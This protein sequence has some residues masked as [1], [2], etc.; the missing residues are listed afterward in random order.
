MGLLLIYLVISV[1]QLFTAHRKMI[2][3]SIAIVFLLIVL[4]ILNT[5]CLQKILNA[6]AH[7]SFHLSNWIQIIVYLAID[8]GSFFAVRYILKN[9]V[10][11]IV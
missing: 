6:A 3:F 4:P 11:L 5:Y 9:K 10:N 1:G 2:T 8:V 7:V